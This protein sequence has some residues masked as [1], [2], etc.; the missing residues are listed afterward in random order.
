MKLF[1][2]MEKPPTSRAIG[3]SALATF[4]QLDKSMA[5]SE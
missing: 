3:T 2:Q 5:T 1:Y 4:E